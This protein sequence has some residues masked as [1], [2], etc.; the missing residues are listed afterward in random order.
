MPIFFRILICCINLDT[1]VVVV[2]CIVFKS[3]G[4]H[5]SNNFLLELENFR[6]IWCDIDMLLK[7]R[8]EC[9]VWV[10]GC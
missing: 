5:L 1:F 2:S 4:G 8:C 7:V 9:H 6:C 3:L 10:L